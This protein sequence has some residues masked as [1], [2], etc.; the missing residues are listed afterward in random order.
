MRTFLSTSTTRKL[1]R[2]LSGTHT[3]PGPPKRENTAR[4]S[5]WSAS[6]SD[7]WPGCGCE[8]ETEREGGSEAPSIGGDIIGSVTGS[9]EGES[10][11]LGALGLGEVAALRPGGVVVLEPRG[12]AAARPATNMSGCGCARNWV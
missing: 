3:R 7:S 2:S 6:N 10:V 9:D 1:L 5:D 12:R 4:S 8:S 11:E